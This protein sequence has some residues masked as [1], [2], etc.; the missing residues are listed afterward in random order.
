MLAALYDIHGN[1]PALDAVLADIERAGITRVVVGGDVVPGPMPRECL[2]RLQGL[3]MSVDYIRGNG[4]RV[5]LA[6]RCGGSIH[7]VPETYRAGIH[8]NAAQLDAA[9]GEWLATWPLTREIPIGDFGDVLFCHATPRN[10]MDIFT[11]LTPAEHLA[12]LFVSA[13]RRLV[14]CGHTHMQFDRMV[15]GI[16]IVNAGSVGMSFQGPGAYWLEIG[17]EVRLRRTSYDLDRAA[18]TIRRTQYPQADQFA[19]ENVLNTPAESAMLEAF[20]KA[21]LQSAS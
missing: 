6:A 1:L 4:E 12:P 19:A 2:A 5:V 17:R 15:G 11:R 7:E 9:T 8:W 10:D 16:R 14:V 3:D 13:N 20:G 18:A 21:E